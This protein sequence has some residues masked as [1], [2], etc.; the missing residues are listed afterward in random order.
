MPSEL[1]A[2]TLQERQ[3]CRTLSTRVNGNTLAL[4]AKD[5]KFNARHLLLKNPRLCCWENTPASEFGELLV[6]SRHAEQDRPK[7][8][9]SFFLR[10][11]VI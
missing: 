11:A 10:S 6:K 8:S 4:H 1:A 7:G 2:E 5:L 9:F 3:L